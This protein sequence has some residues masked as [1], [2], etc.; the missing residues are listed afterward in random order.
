MNKRKVGKLRH[1]NGVT[2]LDN[3]RDRDKGEDGS[4]LTPSQ[5]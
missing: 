3:Y 1:I 4:Y 2:V 5:D